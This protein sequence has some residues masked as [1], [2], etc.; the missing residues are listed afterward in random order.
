MRKLFSMVMIA[1]LLSACGNSIQDSNEQGTLELAGYAQENPITRNL[2]IPTEDGMLN[3]KCYVDETE[4]EICKGTFADG[5]EASA[6]QLSAAMSITHPKPMSDKLDS[7]LKDDCENK[8]LL[9]SLYFK[10]NEDAMHL[11]CNHTLQSEMECDGE[12][13]SMEEAEKRNNEYRKAWFANLNKARNEMLDQF[14][15]LN[16]G[17]VGEEIEAQY[18]K[19]EYG[20]LDLKMPAC[21]YQSFI[22]K[23]SPLLESI[24][25]RG[26]VEDFT[27][28]TCDS[29]LEYKVLLNKQEFWMEQCNE[30]PTYTALNSQDDLNNYLENADSYLQQYIKASNINDIDFEHFTVLVLFGGIHGSTAYPLNVETVCKD[31]P[32]NVYI[33]HCVGKPEDTSMSCPLM[34]LQAPKGEYNVNFV[35]RDLVCE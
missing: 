6:E 5:N 32:I 25:I 11:P 22:E 20:S 8:T 14:I 31:A 29:P 24:R 33:D 7:E 12:I 4:T 10:H 15:M 16:P 21:D 19:T 17:L 30:T 1:C 9:V 35:P 23:N 28:E 18:R 34:I 2:N 3:V 26:L 13:V 27:P